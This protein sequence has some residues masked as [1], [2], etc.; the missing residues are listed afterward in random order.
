MASHKQVLLE[1]SILSFFWLLFFL[2]QSHTT[3]TTTEDAVY[4]GFN[5][6]L[7]SQEKVT[8]SLYYESLCPYCAN[9]IVNE[10]VKVFETDLSSIVNLRLVPWG[11][12]QITPNNSWICQHGRDECL[13]DMVEACVINVWPNPEIHFKFIRC[14]EDLRLRNMHNNWQS[15]FDSL[16]LSQTPIRNC[17]N[18]GLAVR[19]EQGYADETDHLNPPHRFVPWVLVNNL[20]LQEDYQRFVVYI[21][22][23]YRGNNSPESCK[24][25]A[26]VFN[27]LR[28]VNSSQLCNAGN[29]GNTTRRVAN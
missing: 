12:T 1:F 26:F 24:S 22:R 29:A 13:L 7:G 19:L 2:H 8:L 20:P 23:S 27:S 28:A 16:G 14:V 18:T 11:N 4:S 25:E 6:S 17:F 3:A 21:C 5:T 9:F 15:C 10:L